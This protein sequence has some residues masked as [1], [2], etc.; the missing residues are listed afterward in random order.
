MFAGLFRAPVTVGIEKVA[1]TEWQPAVVRLDTEGGA[2]EIKEREVISIQQ[3][4]GRRRT[5]SASPP[6]SAGSFDLC[7]CV[8]N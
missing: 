1:G 5:I 6:A 8:T 3:S 7:S 4:E 2:I